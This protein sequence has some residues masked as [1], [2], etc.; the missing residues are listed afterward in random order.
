MNLLAAAAAH[1]NTIVSNH[2]EEEFR[3]AAQELGTDG[4]VHKAQLA[5]LSK[6][7]AQD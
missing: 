5:E 3:R 2:G 1:G 6:I 4:F 7:L